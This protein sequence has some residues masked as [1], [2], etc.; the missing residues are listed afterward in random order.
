MLVFRLSAEAFRRSEFKYDL[1]VEA[2]KAGKV[3]AKGYV[4][5][6]LAPIAGQRFTVKAATR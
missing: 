2:K 4:I 5:P 1:M 6:F 3:E